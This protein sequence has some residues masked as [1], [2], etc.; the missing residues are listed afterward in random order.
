MLN[1]LKLRN[2][3]IAYFLII[4]ITLRAQNL[5]NDEQT[6]Q[7]FSAL[8]ATAQSFSKISHTPVNLFTGQIKIDLPLYQKKVGSL[9][10]NISLMY[11]GGNGI[12]VEDQGSTVGRGWLLNTGGII[13]RNRR[14]RCDD[15]NHYLEK[16]LIYNNGVHD[17]PDGTGPINTPNYYDVPKIYDADNEHDVFVGRA[18]WLESNTRLYTH[19]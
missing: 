7:N 17:A 15:G 14:G 8:S 18:V 12:K 11:T 5:L 10:F 3:I 1:Y 19:I 16:G 6:Y 13:T 2:F 9:D 4:P